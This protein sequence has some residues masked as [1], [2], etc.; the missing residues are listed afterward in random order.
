MLTTAIMVVML[1]FVGPTPSARA[2]RGRA[3]RGRPDARVALFAL[4]ML[5]LCFTPIPDQR[6]SGSDLRF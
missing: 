1:Y 6:W 5:V 4:V 3:A 2:Q